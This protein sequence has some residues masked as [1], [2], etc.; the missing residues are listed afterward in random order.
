MPR[1]ALNSLIRVFIVMTCQVDFYADSNDRRKQ[2]SSTEHG[3]HVRKMSLEQED[4]E[5]D[6]HGNHERVVASPVLDLCAEFIL[7]W[8]ALLY[9]LVLFHV[10]Y[11]RIDS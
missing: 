10:R 5:P 11:E 8:K 9:L 6:V 7:W 4:K 3:F 2:Y 1:A